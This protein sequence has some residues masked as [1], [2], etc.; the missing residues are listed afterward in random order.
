[1]GERYYVYSYNDVMCVCAGGGEHKGQQMWTA[2]F[3]CKNL[4]DTLALKK[5]IFHTLTRG[6][7]FLS[8]G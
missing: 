4:P 2:T 6:C 3:F 7:I 5:T 8:G 1:M